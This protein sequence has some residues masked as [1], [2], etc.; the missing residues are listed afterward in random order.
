MSNETIDTQFVSEYEE[1]FNTLGYHPKGII[2]PVLDVQIRY[3]RLHNEVNF[4]SEV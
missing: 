2:I 1:I 3:A 4:F